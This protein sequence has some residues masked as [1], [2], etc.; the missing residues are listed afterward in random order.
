[1]VKEICGGYQVKYHPEGE[2]EGKPEV[3]IDFTPPFKRIPMIEGLETAMKTKLPEDL[4]TP[5]ARDALD[6]LCIKHNVD[7][8]APRTTTP[9]ANGYPPRPRPGA[10]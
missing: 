3:T 9:L 4:A 5:A 8:R 2:G 1:M 10:H 7:C 6:A